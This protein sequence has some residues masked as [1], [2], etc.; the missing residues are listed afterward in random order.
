MIV[1]ILLGALVAVGSAAFSAGSWATL[2]DLAEGD[3]AGRLLGL[4]S[5]G[6]AGAAA[7]AG[8]AGPLIDIGERAGPGAGFVTAFLLAGLL[9]VVG[10]VLGWRL[11]MEPAAGFAV[12]PSQGVS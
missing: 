5:W 9:A 4:A 7:A 6:T 11:S 8:L 1:L 12:K 2:T 3:D 10:G